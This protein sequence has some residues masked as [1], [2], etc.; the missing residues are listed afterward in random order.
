M[1]LHFDMRSLNLKKYPIK[2]PAPLL[3]ATLLGKLKPVARNEIRSSLNGII[4][5][6]SENALHLEG[7][8]TERNVKLETD[9]TELQGKIKNPQGIIKNPKTKDL[10]LITLPI[11]H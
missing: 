2:N 9:L 7:G 3:H 8:S 11:A 1:R 6:R 4:L 5:L 10:C